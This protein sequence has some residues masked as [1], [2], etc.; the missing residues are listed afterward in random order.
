MK[1]FGIIALH[2]V[3]FPLVTI[4]IA[5]SLA[6]MEY[7]VLVLMEYINTGVLSVSALT[8]SNYLAFYWI[9]G[10]LL[11]PLGCS[12]FSSRRAESRLKE[13]RL[14]D[15]VEAKKRVREDKERSKNIQ[16]ERRRQEQKNAEENYSKLKVNFSKKQSDIESIKNELIEESANLIRFRDQVAILEE[17]IKNIKDRQP[18][19]IK[20]SGVDKFVDEHKRQLKKLEKMTEETVSMSDVFY[21]A[22]D[23]IDKYIEV[24]I[25]DDDGDEHVYWVS[26]E[27]IDADDEEAIFAKAIKVHCQKG[28]SEVDI[29][30]VE[31]MEPFSRE[32]SEFTFVK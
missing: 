20:I 8:K 31:F 24:I 28:F 13:A 25:P 2:L 15:A 3:L 9:L 14:K 16:D 7:A 12:V 30:D 27:S 21:D 26:L 6:V 23:Y 32:A 29:S 10:A 1:R 22:D 18:K 19:L 17:N 4:T 5:V 11:Y